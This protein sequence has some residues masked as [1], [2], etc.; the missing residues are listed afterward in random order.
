MAQKVAIYIRVS[1]KDESQ[2]T[3]NQLLQLQEFCVTN[4]YIIYK[5]YQDN[6][7]GKKGRS[8]RQ[9][10]DE[11]FKDA[12]AKKFNLVLFWALDRFSREG[13]F[14]TI[15]Y[16]EQLES[17]GIRFRSL[18]EDYL[19]TDNELTRNLLLAMM[20]TFA[21][22]EI[23]KISDR[24]KAGLERAKQKGKT[25]GRVPIDGETIKKI[26]ELRS[27]GSSISK[28]A[29]KLKVSISTVRKYQ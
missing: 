22:L 16:L 29:K 26:K 25:L 27:S 11:L 28:T 3:E 14:K 20:S 17:Y 15:K 1:K 4:S 19:H 9:G 21:K 7:S 5:V 18:T 13:M 2:D 6:E 23:Q 12:R 24:T 10:F 8:E